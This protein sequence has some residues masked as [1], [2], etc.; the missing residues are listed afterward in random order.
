MER[1]DQLQKAFSSLQATYEKREQMEK[2]LR[3]KLE[4]ELDTLKAQQKVGIL[5]IHCICQHLSMEQ[6]DCFPIK[7][8]F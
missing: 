4:K 6:P 7:T 1:L 5:I 2:Q 8:L 3:T